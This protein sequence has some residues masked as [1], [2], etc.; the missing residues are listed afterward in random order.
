MSL[1]IWRGTTL[2]FAGSD[3]GQ[4]VASDRIRFTD[5]LFGPI[6]LCYSSMPPRGAFGTVNFNGIGIDRSG[7]VCNQASVTN[8]RAGIGKMT[9]EWEAGGAYATAA[10]PV[11]TFSM[12][13]QELYPKIERNPFFSGITYQ[14]IQQVY[15]ALYA[16]TQTGGSTAY[17]AIQNN[18][19]PTQVALGNALLNK[20]LNGEETYYLAGWRYTYESFSYSRPSPAIGGDVET[21]G[22]PM[23]GALPSNVSWLR[24]A[25]DVDP[26]GVNGS[27]YR[28]SLTYLGGPSG[29]WDL[30]IY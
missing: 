23:N 17:N 10:L 30:D 14:T 4:F 12:K 2:L 6:N 9:I 3:T 20:L 1:I 27:M 29:H 11:G 22:G 21:P 8:Q 16:Q 7:W 13:P 18:T 26:A 19:N 24:L 5:T 15:S 25:D 28:R